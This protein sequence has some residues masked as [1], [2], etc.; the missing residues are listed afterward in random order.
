MYLGGYHLECLLKSKLMR[1]FGCDTLS[2]LDE[3]LKRRGL[4]KADATVY[5]HEFESLLR[6]SEALDRLR[7]DS[8]LW[9]PFLI[10]NRWV[11][12]WRYDPDLASR[13]AAESF[14]E[15]LDQV[16]GWINANI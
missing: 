3:D 12:A 9:S 6:A 13:S 15:A 8:G 16:A 2:E 1:K 14:L 11:P 7:T 10:V 4:I 5:T